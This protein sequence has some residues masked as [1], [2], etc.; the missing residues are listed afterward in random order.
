MVTQNQGKNSAKPTQ[1][2][3]SITDETTAYKGYADIL[4][5]YKR[6]AKDCPKGVRL[7]LMKGS[8]LRFQFKDP[9]NGT[10]INRASGEQFT[11]SGIVNAVDKAWEIAKALERLDTIGDFWLWYEQNILGKKEL[12]NNLK[13][14]REIFQEIEDNYFKGKHKNTKRQ[15][16]RD[17]SND[18]DTFESFYQSVFKRFIVARIKL[19]N[20]PCLADIKTVI[21]VL[22]DGEKSK[23]G[24]KT[25]K[26]AKGVLLAIARLS[27]D[28][29]RITEY[30]GGLDFEQTIFSDKQSIDYETY[31]AWLNETKLS[32]A[33]Q[34]HRIHRDS[35]LAWLWVSAMCNCYGLRPSEIMAA[36][37]I[38]IA[39]TVD[40]VTFPAITDPSNK[41]K[42]LY[43]GDWTH[44][45]CSV[46]TGKRPCL[47]LASLKVMNDL[48]IEDFPG[49]P[50]IQST[51]SKAIS[52]GYRD[53][54]KNHNSPV[55]QAYAFRH[56]SNQMGEM[57]GIP[58]E[59]RARSLG[60]SVAVN[61]SVYK[62]R[63]NLKTSVDI[64]TN[65]PKQQLP[66]DLALSMLQDMGVDTDNKSVKLILKVIYQIPD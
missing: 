4:A 59:I 27:H 3:I 37:N 20:S 25:F 32:I 42:L 56:L 35:G 50:N 36:K 63:S 39:H 1:D 13:T 30:L 19:D 22:N 52:K 34:R 15:R 17:I 58:Q 7:K 57:N 55:T 29:K 38:D 40:G 54:L 48:K 31:L 66:L 51:A 21:A 64:L 6:K 41:T 26:N 43:V 46:K 9:A 44:N 10:M 8:L 33:N 61:E 49:L 47:P 14:Y 62:K 60:H 24:T 11:D 45:G 18:V 65:H 53:F 12:E 2:Y 5:F 16:S 28:S 23:Q